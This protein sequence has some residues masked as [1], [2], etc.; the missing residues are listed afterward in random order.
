MSNQEF[1]S[2]DE[3]YHPSSFRIR[4]SC[5]NK[6]PS[7]STKWIGDQNPF[8]SDSQ[9]S[10]KKPHKRSS[11]MK[12]NG[13][14]SN[15][16]TGRWTKEEHVKFIEAIN[17]YGRDWKKVQDYVGTRTST[18]ARSHAQKVLP[19]PSCADGVTQSHNSTSTTLTKG[20]PQ[21]NK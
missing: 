12:S 13:A 10:P 9:G 21:S 3:E 16:N 18:Q 6:K 19:H 4:N 1:D 5:P 17:L 15:F 2:S 14:Q 7:F 11:K 8:G 20:S